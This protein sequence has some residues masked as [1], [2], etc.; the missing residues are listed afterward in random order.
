VSDRTVTGWKQIAAHLD[1]S[2]CTA[3][4]W[5]RVAS[6]PDFPTGICVTNPTTRI[7]AR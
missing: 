2:V 5:E 4:R 1:V 7:I 6:L 3:Q